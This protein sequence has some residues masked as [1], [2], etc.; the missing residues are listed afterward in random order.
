M[1][2]NKHL[3]LHKFMRSLPVVACSLPVPVVAVQKCGIVLDYF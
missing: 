3:T 1:K 2:H